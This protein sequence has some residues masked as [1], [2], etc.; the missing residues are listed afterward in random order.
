[1]AINQTIQILGLEELK[2]NIL[3]VMDNMSAKH[4]EPSV[5]ASVKIVG[6]EMKRRAPVGPTGNLRKAT[7]AKLMKRRGGTIRSGMAGVLRGGGKKGYHAW[8]VEYGTTER[9]QKTTGRKTGRM[10]AHPFLR[11]A[12]DTKMADAY[13]YLF[14]RLKYL[15]ENF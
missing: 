13:D 1:M 2:T 10:P 15:S 8:I 12:A 11:P 7:G 4:V 14:K 9:T 3:K 5:L 6:D